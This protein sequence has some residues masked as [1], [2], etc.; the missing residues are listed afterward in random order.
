MLHSILDELKVELSKVF[1]DSLNPPATEEEIKQ[2]EETIQIIFPDDLRELYLAFNGEKESGPGLFFGQPFL[3][4]DE[5][6]NEWKIWQDLEEEYANLL[7][8]ESDPP[9]WVKTMY[10]NRN[11]LPIS[12]DYG[13]NNIGLD[14][15]PDTEGVYGQI[16]RFGRDIDVKYVIAVNTTALLQFMVRQL[17]TMDY[18]VIPKEYDENDLTWYVGQDEEIIFDSAKQ[19]FPI[20]EE[21]ISLEEQL[22]EETTSLE[23]QQTE[24]I[25][26]QKKREFDKTQEGL[27]WLK[28]AAEMGDTGSMNEL[29]FQ[30]LTGTGVERDISE[31]EKWLHRSA[32]KND[33]WAIVELAI[34]LLDGEDLPQN[35]EAGE[36][37]L[38]QAVHLRDP[39]ATRILGYRLIKGDSLQKNVA[40]GEKWLRQA[41]ENYNESVAMR[42]LGLFL[43]KGEELAQNIDEGEYWLE[44]AAEAGDMSAMRNW[45][46]Y[47]IRGL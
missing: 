21:A 19:Y 24:V 32:E 30:F 47:L 4:L 25:D 11:W 45:G 44:R 42:S 20:N 6:M 17:K 15:D 9:G 22:D 13:G 26:L 12:K 40:E 27:K 39:I 23:E 1:P 29:A 28:K 18:T 7:E 14:F 41:A 35:E 16:I 3:S 2:V 36:Q 34:R 46:K 31:G 5:M 33:L 38:R 37:W 10:I 43:L 8:T